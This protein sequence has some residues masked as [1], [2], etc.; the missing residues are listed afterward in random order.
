MKYAVVFKTTDSREAVFS[1]GTDESYPIT[2]SALGLDISVS[3]SNEYPLA[4]Y[5]VSFVPREQVSLHSVKIALPF[6]NNSIGESYPIYIYDNSLCTN[7]FV[8]IKEV[9]DGSDDVTRSREIVTAHNCLGDLNVAFTTYDRFYTEFR[10]DCRGIVAYYAMEDKVVRIGETYIL[11]SLAIDDTLTGIDFFDKYAD[12]LHEK[13]KIG[14]MKPVPAGW[15]SWSCL[16]GNVTEGDVIKQSELLAEKWRDLGADLVQ[17]DDG[18]QKGG[19]FDGTWVHNEDTFPGGIRAISDAIR[20]LGLKMGLWFSPGLIV[21]ESDM[22]DVM[23]DQL[24]KKDG[25]L[26]K[27]FGGD[28]ALSATKNGSVYSLDIGKKES[29]E[30]VRRIF[31]RAID[32]Y[33]AEYFKIDFVMNLLLR[34]VQGG[35]RVEYPDG[36]AVELYRRYISE[37]RSAVGDNIFL[38]ACGS[39]IGESVGIFDS[40]RISADITWEGADNPGHPGAWAILRSDAQ[41]AILRS[42]YH[43]KV[44]INDPDALLLR[45]YQTDKGNDGFALNYEEAKMWATIVATSGGHILLNEE[46]HRLADER[47]EL[48]TSILPPL[49]LAA[50]PRDFYEYPLC[51][52]SYIDTCDSQLVSL[53]NW[54]EGEMKKDFKN[55]FDCRAVMIDCWSRKIIGIIDDNSTFT[56]SPHSCRAFVVRPLTDGFVYSDGNFYLGIRDKVGKEYYYFSGDAP[57]GFTKAY[58]EALDGLYIKN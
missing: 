37:I 2:F 10:T 44:F 25:K 36:Y 57:V 31:R 46:I 4:E 50:R 34:L 54:G 13:Y 26:I 1:C 12:V 8:S 9:K 51:T 55:P 41:C 33:G 29:L 47:R 24:L 7:C 15:S 17:I 53:Y 58:D 11:E 3:R 35:T 6:A 39:P 56:L 32:E 18:W 42:P 43:N 30:Y 45:D 52:E 38:L 40:I 16:Y 23:E 14:E 22:F 19:S 5:S 48:F 49:G 27:S 20:K 28:E 21:D